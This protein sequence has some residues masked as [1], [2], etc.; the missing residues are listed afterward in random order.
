MVLGTVSKL[1]INKEPKRGG[2]ALKENT[3]LPNAST[4]MM[5]PMLDYSMTRDSVDFF[6]NANFKLN[7]PFQM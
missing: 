6:K 1:E 7:S 3:R 4:L 2:H 5:R